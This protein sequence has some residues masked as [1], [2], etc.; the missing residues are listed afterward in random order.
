MKFTIS[1]WGSVMA[2]TIA[3]VAFDEVPNGETLSIEQSMQIRGGNYLCQTGDPNCVIGEN[4]YTCD[5]FEGEGETACIGWYQQI[6]ETSGT[7]KRCLWVPFNGAEFCDAADE[8]PCI[9]A[10]SCT[11]DNEYQECNVD[12]QQSFGVDQTGHRN[13]Y[14]SGES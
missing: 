8:E 7:F 3:A 1:L 14:L 10:A 12:T 2:Q 13:C 11:W 9:Y 6:P 5:N 4:G